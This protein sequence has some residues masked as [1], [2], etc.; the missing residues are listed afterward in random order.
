M[1]PL[2]TSSWL[3]ETLRHGVEPG[4]LAILD[5]RWAATGPTAPERFRQG[6]VPGAQLVDLDTDLSDIDDLAHGRHP[7]PDPDRF[8]QRLAPLGVGPSTRVVAYDEGGGMIAS[9]LYWMLRHWI[10]HEHTAVLDGGLHDWTAGGHTVETGDAAPPTP[11]PEA[12]A[13]KPNDA[14]LVRKGDLEGVIEHV[15][16]HATTWG[17]AIGLDARAAERYR[18]EQEPLDPVAG[19]IPGARNLPCGSLLDTHTRR[20]REAGDLR[21]AFAE[22]GVDDGDAS[23]ASCGSGV[24]ACHL[25]LAADIVG[26]QTP[27]V[28]VGSWSEWCRDPETP[29]ASG[30]S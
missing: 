23:I 18:G 27:R 29:K 5:V 14:A 21:A 28:Y 11:A 1:G 22:V 7:L 20:F 25:V 24:T 8:A 12:I 16:G 6:H 30:V 26:L 13:A 4:S 17:G 2:V 3:A 15:A 19:H 9:R 10:G